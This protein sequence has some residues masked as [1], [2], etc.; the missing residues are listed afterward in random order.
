M[1]LVARLGLLVT[2]MLA[3]YVG[4]RTLL[5]WRRTRMVAEL[6]IGSNVL[7]IACGGAI[8][9][10]LGVL[11]P[12]TGAPAPALPYALGLAGLV[13]HVCAQYIGN[14][15]IFRSGD[16]WPLAPVVA[17]ALLSCAW[18]GWV[19]VDRDPSSARSVMFLGV[20]GIG[21][22]WGAF[23]CFRY[24]ASLRKRAAL[25]LGD[26]F[27]AH[28]IWL[29]GVGAISQTVVISLDLGSWAVVGTALA[30]TP[31]G[32]HVT[33]LIG[34][35]GA[36]AIALAFFPPRAYVRRFGGASVSSE[37]A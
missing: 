17:A 28:R 37:P 34:L 8:L 25:G 9:V 18:M 36:G 14:W 26:A 3:V 22:A 24:A 19:L 30:A 32:L 6:A 5:I 27:I 33:S 23:E 1:E 35:V 4:V 7:G 31:F 2:C 15:K 20:R 11:Y 29:W 12:K 16:R 13:I 21:M 10:G